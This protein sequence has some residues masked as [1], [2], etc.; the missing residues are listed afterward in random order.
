L[1][2]DEGR[3]WRAGHPCAPGYLSDAR[4]AFYPDSVYLIVSLATPDR[5][6]VRRIGITDEGVQEIVIKS[7]DEG[8][9][10]GS[11]AKVRLTGLT[12]GGRIMPI[13]NLLAVGGGKR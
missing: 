1:T 10:K 12:A 3:R 4:R 5:P 2:K 6:V 9:A 7:E 13:G 8:D 11:V